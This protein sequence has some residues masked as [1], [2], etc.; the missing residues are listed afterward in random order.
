MAD[1]N[2][3][4]RQRSPRY[5]GVHLGA[6][7]ERAQ[8]LYDAEKGNAAAVPTVLKHWGYK[9]HSGPASVMLASLK[10]F[11]LLEDV[12]GAGKVRMVR[13]TPLALK[14]IRDPRENSPDRDA[15]IRTAA[16]SPAIHREVLE[17]FAEEGLPSNENL[18]WHLVENL[19]FTDRGA[20]EFVSQ[21]KKTLSLAGIENAASIESQVSDTGENDSGGSGGDSSEDPPGDAPGQRKPRSGMKI[22]Q[23]PLGPEQWATLEG[24]FPLSEQD[25][26]LMLSILDAMKPGLVATP[27]PS[28]EPG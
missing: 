18:L 1:G 4:T 23:I 11:G 20:R 9:G 22:V 27:A 28:T 6:A 16:M 25:W 2:S 7:L 12:Q 8:W 26:T 3:S 19:G 17:S 14:I 13:L 21:F 5:P 15:A 10:Q 24:A